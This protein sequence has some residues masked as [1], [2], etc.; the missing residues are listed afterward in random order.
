MVTYELN[1]RVG[2][3][4]SWSILLGDWLWNARSCRY[5]RN[6]HTPACKPKFEHLLFLQVYLY[7]IVICFFHIGIGLPGS[8]QIEICPPGFRPEVWR[9]R[10]FFYQDCLVYFVFHDLSGSSS[11]CHCTLQR[12]ASLDGKVILKSFSPCVSLGP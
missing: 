6:T 8:G 11:F 2:P 3:L 1:R 10:G 12:E 5:F 7:K 4:E 9:V